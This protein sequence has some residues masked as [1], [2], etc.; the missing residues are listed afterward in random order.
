MCRE[1]APSSEKTG[2]RVRG[3]E[4]ALGM[5]GRAVLQEQERPRG[6]WCWDLTEKGDTVRFL[7]LTVVFV[8]VALGNW[9]EQG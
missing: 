3:A 5:T 2:G 6:S 8:E 7:Q 9:A 4:T 1:G